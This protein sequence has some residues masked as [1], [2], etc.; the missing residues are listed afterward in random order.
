[1]RS[2]I[3]LLALLIWPLISYGQQETD[4]SDEL[5]GLISATEKAAI[6][7][8]DQ[9]NLHGVGYLAENDKELSIEF[10]VDTF[11]IQELLRRRFDVDYSTNGIVQAFFY[12]ET[13]YDD[14]LNKYYRR[15][16][17]RLHAEDKKVLRTAQ[18]HWLEFRDAEIAFQQRAKSDRYTGGGSMYRIFL[19]EAYLDITEK[20]VV[21]LYEYLSTLNG[22]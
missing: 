9:I 14:L 16:M 10:A 8:K 12:A 5:A 22:Y 3:P 15:L 18:R 17:N 2:L 11:K 13:Q 21:E 7:F 6:H 20:R 19:A 4:I 1:M